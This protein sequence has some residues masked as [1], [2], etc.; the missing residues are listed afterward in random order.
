MLPLRINRKANGQ[1]RDIFIK[2]LD[3]RLLNH[4]PPRL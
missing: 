3:R 1:A 2:V 4:L